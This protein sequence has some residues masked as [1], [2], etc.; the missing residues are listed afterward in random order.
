MVIFFQA[1]NN[2]QILIFFLEKRNVPCCTHLWARLKTDINYFIATAKRATSCGIIRSHKNIYTASHIPNIKITRVF[3]ALIIY[4]SAHKS[5]GLINPS[6]DSYFFKTSDLH[7]YLK[8]TCCCSRSNL[9]DFFFFF[10]CDLWKLIL[11]T[12]NKQLE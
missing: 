2:K 6:A 12:Q 9:V 11:E 7:T 3:L 10:F 8:N 1:A 4:I 5:N